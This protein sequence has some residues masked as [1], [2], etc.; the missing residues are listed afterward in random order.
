MRD[1]HI[2]LAM[3]GRGSRFANAGF[4]TPKPLIEVDGQAMF[5]KALSSLDS[6]EATKHYTIVMRAEHDREYDLQAKIKGILPEANVVITDEEPTGAL[7]D[8]YRAKP[9]LGPNQGIIMLDCDLWFHSQPYNEMVQDSLSGKSDIQGGLLTFKADNPR[10]SYA[11]VDEN[12]IVSRTAEKK[13]ISDR[14]ITGAYYIAT[15]EI[16]DE[17]AQKLLAQPLTDEMPEYYVSHIFNVILENGGKVKA[18][19]VE[20]FASFGTPEEL[21]DYEKANA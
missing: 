20:Q 1:L 13:V 17:A 4:T 16:F 9:H 2:I 11:K 21:A 15:T 3:A 8:A 6:I 18:A 14:A 19:P 12:W 10:Y 7:R 5:M